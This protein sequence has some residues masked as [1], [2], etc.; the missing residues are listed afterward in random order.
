M[1]ENTF[2]CANCG[3]TFPM[4][5]GHMVG[6][7]QLCHDCM[8]SETVECT[9][10][11]SL[12][13]SD[14]NSGTDAIPLCAACFDRYEYA[15]CE[16]CGVLL[17]GGEVYY[18]GEE[19]TPYCRECYERYRGSDVIHAYNY[20]PDPIFYGEGP[21]YF[22]VELEIDEGGERNDYAREI[23]AA[24]NSED[25]SHIYAKRDGSLNNGFEIVSEPMSL[26]YHRNEMPWEQVLEKARQLGFKSHSASTCGLH[27]HI[28]RLAFGKDEEQ[29]EACI[30]R[31]LYFFEKHWEELLKFSRRTPR[32]LE[33]WAA[34]YGY[35]EQ[36]MEI[37]SHAKKGT[38]AGRYT[39][40]NLENYSTIEVRMFRGTL[41]LNTFIA[42]LQM[43][44]LICSV[45]ISLSDDELKALSW[46]TFV[47][48]I[49]EDNYPEL[50]KYLME[51]RLYVN[52][53]VELEEVEV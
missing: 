34:R 18:A 2:I 39:C 46:S 26:D 21:R 15:I 4:Q 38:H 17:R 11:H 43:V 47:S 45:A 48:G 14:L 13:Y 7:D 3:Q 49:T 25:M 50:V 42:T 51:K 29:Q 40:V 20:K 24:G 32:Q 53:V 8:E 28:S 16:R 9:H 36:P 37:L 10:C 52:D 1:E 12:I 41:K 31:I 33:R 30:A 23:L 27:V 19:D 22:G 44:N 6:N 5:E 35:K